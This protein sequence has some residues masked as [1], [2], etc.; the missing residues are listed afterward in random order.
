MARPLAEAAAIGTWEYEPAGRRF[1][2]DARGRE[3][4]GL[5]GD[6]AI[7]ARDLLARLR[8]ACRRHVRRLAG[9]LGGDAAPRAFE[10][11]VGCAP[12]R[13]A[14]RWL[15]VTGR[16]FERDGAMRVWVGTLI[17]VTEA[18]RTGEELRLANERLSS[19]LRK[20]R[21]G[22]WDWD[23]GGDRLYW[24]DEFRELH[25]VGPATVPTFDVWLERVQPV[26]RRLLRRR[27]ALLRGGE[28]TAWDTE[29]RVRAEGVEERWLR[30]RGTLERDGGSPS[31]LAGIVLDISERKRAELALQQL[32]KTLELR[33][34]ERTSILELQT[35]QLRRL[36]HQL[37]QTE[38]RE[39]KKLASTLHDGLQ[40]MLVATR[41]RL[42]LSKGDPDIARVDAMIDESISVSRSL[43]TELSPPVLHDADLPGALIWLARWFEDRCDFAVRVECSESFPE[44]SET[45]KLFL[46]H[47]VRELLLNV[48]RHAGVGAATV[49]LD[50]AADAHLV[51]EVADEG[52]GFDPRRIDAAED[53]GGYGLF[54][55]RERLEAFGGRLDAGSTPGRGSRVS[56]HLPVE[57]AA[58]VGPIHEEHAAPGAPA[59]GQPGQGSAGRIRVLLADDHRLV[60]EGL[61]TL[62]RDAG[63]LEVVGVARDG[64]EAIELAQRLQPDVVLIDVNLPRLDG[65]EATRRIK[66][67]EPA[68]H[69]IGLSLHGG[70]AMEQAM[71]QAGI[72]AYL[73]KDSAADALLET[74]EG[75]CRR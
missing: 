71:W 41:M 27:L 10:I 42:R 54:S 2:A 72:S 22:V 43:A 57:G 25:G 34:A 23:L 44:V 33:V 48:L 19:A 65:I 6:G 40:Q 50:A 59:V 37:T 53:A 63:S 17:D 46:F 66:K 14:E 9:Q 49:R 32:N 55:I 30:V 52:A 1:E 16:V 28:A 67:L 75:L 4:V 13:G 36:A 26:D 31:R 73:S 68:L 45:Y 35:A 12:R 5:G 18:R 24:S 51:I 61:A 64:I 29:Y 39:R 58:G 70:E 3:L 7:R 56:L 69:V 62:L 47:A 60:R 15:A 38:Q 74:I 21:S 8:P 11:V 20:S